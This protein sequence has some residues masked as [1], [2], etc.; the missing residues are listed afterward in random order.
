MQI[1]AV[2][3]FSLIDYP[4][5]SSA[6]VF[7]P[8]CNFRCPFCHNS[9]FVLPEKLKDIYKSLI[10]EEAV[11]NFLETR[12][13]LL[14]GVSICWGEPSMQKDL[15]D[16]CAK[17]KSMWFLVKLDTNGRAPKLIKQLLDEK[18]VDYIAMDVKNEVWKFRDI[19]WIELDENPYL[20]SI[21]LLL[22]SDIDY[23]FRTTV[24]KW[25]HNKEIIENIAKYISGAKSYYL[26]NYKWWN[27]LN[28]NFEWQSFNETELEYLKTIASKYIKNVWIRN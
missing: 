2:N 3:K 9:E 22:N 11:F 14:E 6:I 10:P 18:L 15:K 13:W 27:T 23:E 1:S 5:K 12:K 16:F 25:F 24:I 7:T 26:Q 20:E 19:V 8:W 21:K 17:V 4:G 28:P